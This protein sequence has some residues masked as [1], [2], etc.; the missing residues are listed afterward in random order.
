VAPEPDDVELDPVPAPHALRAKT[1][2]V[3]SGTARNLPLAMF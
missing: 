1:T 2:V 3:I